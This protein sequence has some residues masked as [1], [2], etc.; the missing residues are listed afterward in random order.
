MK[1]QATPDQ[2]VRRMLGRRIGHRADPGP[3]R[4][5]VP[6]PIRPPL[7]EIDFQPAAILLVHDW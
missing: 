5:A 6:S 1:M 7:P 4:R 2:A 3:D